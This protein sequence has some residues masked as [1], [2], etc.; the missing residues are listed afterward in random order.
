MIDDRTC[1]R[2]PHPTAGEFVWNADKNAFG[3]TALLGHA[4]GGD[5]VSPYAA[6]ARASDLA[7]LPPT[8][9]ATGAIDLFVDEDLDY[10]KRLMAAGVACE[11]HVYPGAFHA[12]NI[13]PDARVAQAARRDSIEVNTHRYFV[14]G[15]SN[16]FKSEHE[17]LRN[18]TSIVQLVQ[19]PKNY[20]YR[21]S[22]D[23]WLAHIRAQQAFYLGC[24]CSIAAAWVELAPGAVREMHWHPDNDEWQYWVSGHARMTV[25]GSSGKARTF[26]FY[27]GD[28]GYVPSAMGHYF[29]NVGD[30]PVQM[31]ELFRSDHFA[32]VSANQWL[33]L[34]P[35]D[36]VGA[37]LNLS[38]S[39]IDALRKDKPLIMPAD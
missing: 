33:G 8:Y 36:V 34:T 22:R 11:L 21:Y 29:E 24:V 23:H 4:P 38:R 19:R 10:A 28:V 12:F 18:R 9:I 7:G 16:G 26:D 32:D 31:L 20:S 6:A 27:G 37:T 1:V 14:F 2:A 3:W 5:H 13:V 30:E 25:F 35:P 15:T 39:T 17:D